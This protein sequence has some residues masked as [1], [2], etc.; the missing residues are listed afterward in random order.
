M[1]S[2]S[3]N[4][5]PELNSTVNPLIFGSELFATDQSQGFSYN[6]NLATPMNYEIGPGDV[7]NLVVYGVQ[8]FSSELPVSKEGFIQVANVG[9]IKVA[10]L[11]IEAAFEK[12]KLQMA[13]SAYSSIARGES[14]LSLTLSDIRTI[15][16]TLIGAARS[17]NYLSLI[18]I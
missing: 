16:V 8:E 1:F 5:R 2:E 12:V 18:H 4:A 15:Q 13:R 9:Q 6:Q 3:A 11:T 14:K 10:G 17:G 7:L